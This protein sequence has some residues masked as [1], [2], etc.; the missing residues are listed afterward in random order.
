MYLV[1]HAYT[2]SAEAR[3]GHWISWYQSNTVVSHAGARVQ[4]LRKGNQCA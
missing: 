4:M 1:L 3:S 2:M